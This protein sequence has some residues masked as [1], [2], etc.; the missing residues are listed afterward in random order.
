MSD[1]PHADQ[2]I[3]EFYQRLAHNVEKLKKQKNVPA[4]LKNLITMPDYLAIYE[5]LLNNEAL[6]K[7]M[8]EKLKMGMP[9]RLSKALG[10]FSRTINIIF[11]AESQDIFLMLETKTK[12][13]AG[14]KS[15]K[16]PIFRGASKTI[17][18]VWRIDSPHPI[19]YANAVSY[20][21]KG[22]ATIEKAKAEAL[23]SQSISKKYSHF[24]TGLHLVTTGAVFEKNGI[25]HKKVYDEKISFYSKWASENNLNSFLNGVEA[26]TLDFEE[27]NLL[28]LQLLFAVKLIHDENYI[29]QDI[30]NMNIFISKKNDS[31][32]LELGDFGAAINA[33][34]KETFIATASLKYES[35]EIS[36]VHYFFKHYEEFNYA[37]FHD[38]SIN[39]QGRKHFLNNIDIFHSLAQKQPNEL[40]EPHKSNDMWA[41]GIV[42]CDLYKPTFATPEG[43]KIYA[44]LISKLLHPDRSQRLT[45]HDAF[46]QHCLAIAT[47][48]LHKN[49]SAFREFL[50]QKRKKARL[51]KSGKLDKNFRSPSVQ[52]PTFTPS[53]TKM[54]TEAV[55][56]T[57]NVPAMP[58]NQSDEDISHYL[59]LSA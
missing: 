10:Y 41:V 11:D 6:K 37:Y 8:I 13:A 58:V 1:A 33:G 2:K 30:K 59:N 43:K 31:F 35:P 15:H 54:V 19:K 4:K 21:K 3:S 7:Q 20:G 44:N 46:F 23:I 51:D 40:A 22:K 9:I 48:T 49:I 32:F 25:R 29:H 5:G 53:Y 55:S 47:S 57:S 18:P 16:T 42:L 12:T 14:K 45:A 56:V 28:A 50:A 52:T 38:P 26:N 27:R 34:E 39:S 17:K 36:A 24:H